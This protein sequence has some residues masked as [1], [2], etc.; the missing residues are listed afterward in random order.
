MF[1]FLIAIMLDT[2][3]KLY[4]NL[5]FLFEEDTVIYNVFA[6]IDLFY[7]LN[8]VFIGLGMCIIVEL[9]KKQTILLMLILFALNIGASIFF[10]NLL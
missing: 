9:T 1:K 5:A 7:I 4:T 2:D 10:Q 3:F 8:F 6:S